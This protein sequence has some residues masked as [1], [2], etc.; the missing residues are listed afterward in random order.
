MYSSLISIRN[1]TNLH[2]HHA[3]NHHHFV[4]ILSFL[5]SEQ[6]ERDKGSNL[7]FM[8]RLPFAAGRVF[9]I[10]ML[11][12]LLYQVWNHTCRPTLGRILLQQLENHTNSALWWCPGVLKIFFFRCFLSLFHVS[13]LWRITWS[14]SPGC[15]WDWTPLQDRDTSALWV[16]QSFQKGETVKLTVLNYF[17]N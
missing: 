3:V 9:S 10:S 1:T 4:L 14:S 7:A 13:L 12:T 17:R 5:L 8:F 16:T 15:C 11:D 2:H 6:K